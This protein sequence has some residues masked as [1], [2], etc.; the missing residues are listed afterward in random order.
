MNFAFPFDGLKKHRP[1]SD[2]ERIMRLSMLLLATVTVLG[3]SANGFASERQIEIRWSE[4]GAFL[5]GGKLIG[6]GAKAMLM[7]PNGTIVEGQIAGVEKE[8][9]ALNVSKSSDKQAYPKGRVSIPRSLVTTI[10]LTQTKGYGRAFGTIAGLLGGAGL[11]TLVALSYDDQSASSAARA[12][13]LGLWAGTTVGG[14]YVG[15]SLDRK[16]TII[17]ILPG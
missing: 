15:R 2:K 8:Q 7:L 13:V 5:Q 4:L 6:G 1:F 10:R 16:T 3:L 14:Y 11:G 12:G 17:R 9:I